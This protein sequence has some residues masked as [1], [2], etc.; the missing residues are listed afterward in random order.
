MKS[1]SLLVGVVL[2]FF[3]VNDNDPISQLIKQTANPL[4]KRKSLL[5]KVV[6]MEN[7]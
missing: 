7:K 6:D 5:L 2:L 4:Q 3:Y 1:I